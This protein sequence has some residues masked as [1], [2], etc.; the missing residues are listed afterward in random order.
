MAGRQDGIIQAALREH[1]TARIE[2]VGK[3]RTT[4]GVFVGFVAAAAGLVAAN[5]MINGADAQSFNSQSRSGAQNSI[6]KVGE[7]ILP[8]LSIIEPGASLRKD[9]EPSPAP[10]YLTKEFFEVAADVI[11]HNAGVTLEE[12][13]DAL[14]EM[15]DAGQACKTVGPKKANCIFSLHGVKLD[16]VN[17]VYTASYNRYSKDG[18]VDLGDRVVGAVQKGAEVV[19]RADPHQRTFPVPEQG[20]R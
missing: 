8:P 3:P 4:V 12:A 13:S 6:A 10:K 7:F 15:E 9:E 16:Y 14:D 2:C 19:V 5:V 18:A 17:E 11:R 1:A 20:I